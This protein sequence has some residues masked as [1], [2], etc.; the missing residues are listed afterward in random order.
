MA[1]T[2]ETGTGSRIMSI[3]AGTIEKVSLE[4]GGTRPNIVF[5]DADLD[6]AVAGSLLAIYANAGQR[7][8]VRTRLFL[9]NDVYDRFTAD[10]VAQVRQIRVG[11]PL[12]HETQMGP[13]ISPAQRD[14]VLAY[15]AMVQEDG[16]QLL[17]GGRR[18]STEE[19][20]NGNFVGPTVFGD[21]RSDIRLA[22]EEVFGRSWP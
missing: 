11:D 10:Y 17:S 13:V 14:R 8:T 2:G 18:V 1:F 4:L 12:E 9:Y 6:E 16:A 19:L 20:K 21:V 5:S 15:C 22:R 3:A 7:C